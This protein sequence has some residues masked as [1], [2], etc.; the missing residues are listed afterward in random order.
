M[1]RLRLAKDRQRRGVGAVPQPC[2]SRRERPGCFYSTTSRLTFATPLPTIPRGWVERL[3]NPSVLLPRAQRHDGFCRIQPILRAVSLLNSMIPLHF[4]DGIRH[5]MRVF[6]SSTFED[7]K[8]YR[9]QAALAVER[10][11][12]QGI[13]MEVFGARSSGATEVC[14]E[15]IGASDAFIGI[16]AYRYGF[17]PD[18]ADRSITE[19]EFDLAYSKKPVFCFLIDENFPW[20]PLYIEGSPG[21]EK[22][23]EFKQRLSK[24][25]VVDRFTTAEDL[26]FKV[27][28]ALGR[29]LITT[30]VTETLQKAETGSPSQEGRTQVARR[31]VRAAP[32]IKGTRLLL[33]NDIP[34]EMDHV[35]QLLADL[36]VVVT[37]A[38][39]TDEALGVLN[40]GA[41]D[42][43][44]SD[45][46]RGG[47]ADDGLRLLKRMRDERLYLPIIFS[48]GHY[49]PDRGV[50]PFCFGITNRVDELLNLVF[51]VVERVRG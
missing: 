36:G 43:V 4:L 24:V 35:V 31:T 39:S 8:E 25:V 5:P 51:D 32:L 49:E 11:G 19:Q 42:L 15:E 27:S 37:I 28:S 46:A 41:V 14:T 2:S 9:A 18:G 17:T 45:M 12:Q 47:V 16:Y 30:R 21:K 10:L 1:G 6:L 29:H 34:D 40:N 23:A 26:A 13:R 22:L 3:Q 48:V 7:L 20:L 38:K 50:P 44:V 33:V